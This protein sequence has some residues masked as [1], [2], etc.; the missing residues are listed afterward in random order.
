MVKLVAVFLATMLVVASQAFMIGGVGGYTDR[1]ELLTDPSITPLVRYAAE[2]LALQDNLIL[3][4]IKV[5]RVQTQVVAGVNYKLDFTA[6]PVN[7]IHVQPKTC[8]AIIYVRFD[9]TMKL[10]NAHC[11]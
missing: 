5:T 7:G 1:P 2:Q 9:S 10:T 8:Q 6:Q 3:D 4:N 11:D